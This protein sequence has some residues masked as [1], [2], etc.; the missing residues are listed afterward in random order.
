MGRRKTMLYITNT[1]THITYDVLP[2]KIPKSLILKKYAALR[3]KIN[4]HN[5]SCPH[6]AWLN[7]SSIPP[8]EPIPLPITG[9]LEVSYEGVLYVHHF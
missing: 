1:G 4:T 8:Y 3:D 2:L 9:T 5:E 7:G 6:G